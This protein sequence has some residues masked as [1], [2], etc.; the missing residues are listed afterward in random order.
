[1]RDILDT[2]GHDIEAAWFAVDGEIK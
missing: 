1:M 2:D